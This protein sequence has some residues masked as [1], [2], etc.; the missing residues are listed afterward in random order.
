MVDHR[1]YAPFHQHFLVARLDLDVDGEENT[2]VEVD[3]RRCRSSADN[4]YGLAVVTEATPIA[5]GGR[6]R[7]RL[8]LGDPAG[9]KVVNPNRTNA[10]GTTG[11]LQAGAR[12]ASFPVMM[13]PDDRRSTCARR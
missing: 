8:Q 7:P 13:D 10:H 11:R 6:V 12:R 2:V 5:L 1:T 4:P 3:S 9:W